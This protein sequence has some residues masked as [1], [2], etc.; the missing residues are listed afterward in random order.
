M[1]SYLWSIITV[2][3]RMRI[4]VCIYDLNTRPGEVE[5][6]AQPINLLEQFLIVLRI[7]VFVLWKL[8]NEI[9]YFLFGFNP[10]SILVYPGKV[11]KMAQIKKICACWVPLQKHWYIDPTIIFRQSLSLYLFFS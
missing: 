1:Y 3:Y 11:R 7:C 10:Q 4:C 8:V 6:A 2:N 9:A 5:N